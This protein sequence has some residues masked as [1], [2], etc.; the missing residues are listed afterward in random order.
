MN[1]NK[2]YTITDKIQ[3]T[4]ILII[5]FSIEMQCT[6]F[7]APMKRTPLCGVQKDGIP[8]YGVPKG[9]RSQTMQHKI[10]NAIHW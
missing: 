6:Y 9:G 2:N 3:I 8:L 1:Y 5:Y 4:D 7:I 10:T